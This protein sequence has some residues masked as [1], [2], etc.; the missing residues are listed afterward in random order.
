MKLYDELLKANIYKEAYE[1]M[2]SKPGNVKGGI[3]G[4]SMDG[5]SNAKIARILEMMKNRSFKFKPS[6]RI[7]IPK[8]DGSKR[9]IGIPSPIDKV[10]QKAIK[11]IVEPIYEQI[12][13]DTSHGFRPGRS[14][15]SA[16][17]EISN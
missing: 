12:F 14:C 16:L 13:L 9:S 8:K 6:K 3:N 4:E 10:V 7:E 17:K 11:L 15:H 5:F 1:S 2:K